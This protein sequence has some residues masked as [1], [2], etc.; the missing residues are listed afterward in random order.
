[1]GH[2][3]LVRLGTALC[4][5]ALATSCGRFR[6]AKECERFAGAVSDWMKAEIAPSPANADTA[7][8]V[9]DAQATARRY[10]E[11]DR[12]LSGLGL[13]SA[14]LVP[15][16]V[17]YREMAVKSADALEQVARALADADLERARK[18]RVEFDATIR[19][20]APLVDQINAVCR[21]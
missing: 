10:R 4:L 20:E 6:K 16:V 13:K 9:A 8:L 18:L 7:T 1:M 17:R 19:A 2:P 15:L 21:R 5:L 3:R 12:S 14:D 11:L